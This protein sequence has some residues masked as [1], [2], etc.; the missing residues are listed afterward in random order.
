MERQA[1]KLNPYAQI[2]EYA[3]RLMLYPAPGLNPNTPTL[4]VSKG[5]EAKVTAVSTLMQGGVLTQEELGAAFSES[6]LQF[7][8]DNR[9]LVDEAAQIDVETTLSRSNAFYQQYLTQKQRDLLRSSSVLVLG[10]GG[11]GSMMAWHF[12]VMGISELTVVDFDTVEP[13]NLNRIAIFSPS[14]VGEKKVDVLK[15]RLEPLNPHIT[16]RTID[17]KITS[18]EILERLCIERHYD[19]I[20][21]AL[22]SPTE[23]PQW[24]DSVCKKHKLPYVAGINV[25]NR[26]L[27]GPTY[28]PG[29]AETGWSEIFRLPE[30][31]EKAYGTIPSTG[32]MLFHATDELAIE[33]AKLLTRQYDGLKYCNVICMEDLFTGETSYIR[34][35]RDRFYRE[36]ES[37]RSVLLAVL[38]VLFCGLCSGISPYF[39]V[40]AA[41]LALILPFY[42]CTQAKHIVQAAFL[43]SIPVAVFGINLLCSAASVP[44]G[45][46]GYV[47]LCLIAV[48]N[49][50]LLYCFAATG[51]IKLVQHLDKRRG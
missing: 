13:S 2:L 34:N 45:S 7:L 32:T 29:Y 24:L 15:A 27:I 8:L 23:F 37:G 21:K 38:C 18:Q 51:I 9:V 48:S 6:E 5:D 3:D 11:I 10:G 20:V 36:R 33:A 47:L 50:G 41:L 44:L 14:D 28:L 43:T 16:I 31:G 19:L 17:Q 22:D 4:K 25:R 46:F 12:A 49:V 26:T 39:L 40:G 1:C 30:A 35:K 42:S